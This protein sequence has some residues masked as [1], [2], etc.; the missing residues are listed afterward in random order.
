MN[1][2]SIKTSLFL[3]LAACFA[4][5]GFSQGF[6]SRPVTV[7]VGFEPGGGT[8]T[9]AR[10]VQKPLSDSLGQ[11]V[12]VE[13]RA[14]AGGNIAVDFVAKSAPDG[15][16]L[17]LANVGSL[18]VNPHL[19]KLPYDPFRD[20]A[21]ITM[22]VVFPNLIVVHPSVPAKNLAELI[23]L[24]KDKPGTV[25]YGSSGIG[26]AGHL[27]GE[28]LAMMAKVELVHVPYKGGG[29]AMAGL[30]GGQIMIYFATPVAPLPHIKAG[31][32]RP[33]ATTGAIRSTLLPDYPTVAESGYPGYEAI[34]WYAYLAPAKTPREVV[35]RLNRELVKV[36]NSAETVAALH[37][38]GVEPKPGSPEDLARF[39]KS[40]YETWGKVV[41]QAGIKPQ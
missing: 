12:V 9:V 14:G 31:K 35:D 30:L 26:G 7:V 22:A 41:K 34:N 28:L 4:Q 17:V 25:T 20:L 27:A 33:I 36:L 29:P 3:V 10:I 21:P 24:A 32:A 23:A 11:Q 8:D 1:V 18:T 2:T 19:L 6:P 39:M 13:N 5:T 15:H 16:T 38:Q 40:E 37:K